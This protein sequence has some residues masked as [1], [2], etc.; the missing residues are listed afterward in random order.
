MECTAYLAL[1]VLPLQVLLFN[2]SQPFGHSLRHSPVTLFLTYR[3]ALQSLAKGLSP[4]PPRHP[5]M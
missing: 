2:N 3:H 4:E 1:L 5:H